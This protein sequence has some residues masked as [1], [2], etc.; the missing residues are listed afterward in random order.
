MLKHTEQFFITLFLT[1]G[2]FSTFVQA[3]V[4]NAPGAYI[5]VTKLGDTNTSIRLSSADNSDNE[6][7][8]YFLIYDDA[9]STLFD[10][11]EVNHSNKTHIYSNVTGLTCNKTYKIIAIA[12]NN[13]GNSSKSDARYFNIK[14][15]FGAN[16]SQSSTL[17]APGPYIG[18]TAIEGSKTSV[19]V[20]FKD[21]NSNED[22]FKIIG[23]V[24]KTISGN[25]SG[26]QVYTT[27][28]G[29]TCGQKYQIQALAYKDGV[30]SQL[31]DRRNFDINET[32]NFH[33]DSNSLANNIKPVI[34]LIGNS[35]ITL[36]I[37][38][39]YIDAGATASDDIDGSITV[40]I[41]TTSTV[42]TSIIG[43]YTV[44]YNVKDSSNNMAIEIVRTVRVIDN[45]FA[46][47]IS[48]VISNFTTGDKLSN[49]T[50]SVNGQ[51]IITNGLGEYNL[52]NI[53][54]GNRI[55]VT[56]SKNG[57]AT[58]SEIV[59]LSNTN[60]TVQDFNIALLPVA[61]T[62]ELDPTE[63]ATIEVPNSP[64]RLQLSANSLVQ[65]DGNLPVGSVRVLFTPIDPT[66]DIDI[67]PGDMLTR[68]EGNQL[69]PIESYG[70]VNI[71]LFDDDNNPINLREGE[72]ANLRIPIFSRGGSIPNSIPLYYFDT[73][74][75]LWVE[76]G[77]IRRNTN[78]YE[79]TI[80]YFGIWNADYLFDNVTIHGCVQD[81]DGNL[82]SNAL[83]RLEG[84]NYNGQTYAY[85]ASNGQFDIIAKRDG[86]ALLVAQK[87]LKT[88]SS[89]TIT[90][91]SDTTLN[92]CLIFGIQTQ[93][94]V[95]KLTWGADP[96]D[97]DTH[98]VQEGG[99]HIYY[100]NKGN[101]NSPT[102]LAELD[103][104]DTSSFGPEVFTAVDFPAA[105]IYH[106]VVHHFSGS[107]TISN[108]PARVELRVNGIT[109][110][111]IPSADSTARYWHVFDIIVN[112]EGNI[113][114]VEINNFSNTL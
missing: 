52:T 55:V 8:F 51:E 77:A 105:G 92:E 110:T 4:P 27:L 18:I 2:I 40:D 11:I 65:E 54:I 3:D 107:S 44:K 68:N 81:T 53:T 30:N 106:Y 41:N 28:T 98:V 10:T 43:T 33:C 104:D 80:T 69:V 15:T 72:S 109:T 60:Q 42:N 82:I 59:S 111:F 12:Y 31:S 85:S 16:C 90:P 100:I 70:A 13:D 45:N 99:Y 20:N 97:L 114:I 47:S 9:T 24:N 88:S 78:Y 21:N 71:E 102:Y 113:E 1:L 108:S 91:S 84:I 79:G 37:G 63:D 95:A 25:N 74:S 6:N 87:G 23:D 101:L 39:N 48:G 38:D 7:G 50:V 29:L 56:A 64:A 22:G 89:K 76:D 83:V 66:Q 36:N 26:V 5:G 86:N 32:F 49:A 73:T 103:V 14:N 61:F 19:R 34:T 96:R 17:N 35:N 62:Y 67:M 94:L 93:G 75:G 57:Y 58:N 46:T 112:D